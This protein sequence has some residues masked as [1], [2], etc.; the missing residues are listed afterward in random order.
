MQYLLAFRHSELLYDYALGVGGWH[1][2]FNGIKRTIECKKSDFTGKQSQTSRKIENNC[3]NRKI[4]P[5]TKIKMCS[6]AEHSSI[7]TSV[8]K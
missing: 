1:L 7:Q 6:T 5:K 3:G 8:I 2:I 4:P